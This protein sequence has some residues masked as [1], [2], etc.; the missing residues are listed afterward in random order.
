MLESKDKST[1][2]KAGFLLL[3][4]EHIPYPRLFPRISDNTGDVSSDQ[5]F[6]LRI[7]AERVSFITIW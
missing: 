2:L 7:V 5:L 3:P 6:L 1:G 4:I